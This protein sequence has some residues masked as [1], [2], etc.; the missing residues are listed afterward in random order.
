MANTHINFKI[1]LKASYDWFI[2]WPKLTCHHIPD[3]DLGALDVLFLIVI[4][5]PTVPTEEETEAERGN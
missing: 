3:A 4:K 2:H 5:T 1:F